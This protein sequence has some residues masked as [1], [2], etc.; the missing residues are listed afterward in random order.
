MCL[1]TCTEGSE[2][3]VL[4]A[5]NQGARHGKVQKGDSSDDKEEEVGIQNGHVPNQH[6]CAHRDQLQEQVALDGDRCAGRLH[7]KSLFR[8]RIDAGRRMLEQL[9]LSINECSALGEILTTRLTKRV[10]M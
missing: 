10:A 4:P 3:E 9:A 8:C 1:D 5:H 2:D 6:V 7:T